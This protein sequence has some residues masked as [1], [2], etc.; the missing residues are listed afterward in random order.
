M[1]LLIAAL[2]VVVP[3]LAGAQSPR[4][5]SSAARSSGPRLSEVPPLA[6]IG[7][8]LPDITPTLAPLGLPA[9]D[10]GARQAAE[11][12]PR[13]SRH[14]GGRRG[15]RP[16][17]GNTIYVVP[18][19]VPEPAPPPP[20]DALPAP[21]G[22][23]WLDVEPRAAEVHLDGALVGT[24]LD[25]GGALALPAGLHRVEI[26]A[27]GYRGIDVTVRVDAG[28]G[29]TL[30]RALEPDAMAPPPPAAVAPPAAPVTRKPFYLVPG[31]YLGDVPPEEAGLPARCDLTKT[32]V[33]RP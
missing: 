32:V 1:R 9:P 8:A 7:L 33:V 27:A 11:P 13:G 26:Q 23:L 14:H 5:D 25:L 4:G 28:G 19:Y 30:R 16:N 24:M 17:R 15:V 3:A 18:A 20:A 21:T 10:A 29:V 31:C 12:T 6:P 2:L 22:T